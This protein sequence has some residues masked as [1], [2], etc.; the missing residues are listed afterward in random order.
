VISTEGHV[1]SEHYETSQGKSTETIKNQHLN[2]LKSLPAIPTH[3]GEQ[4]DGKKE[5]NPLPFGHQIL[6][7]F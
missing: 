7:H 1:I 5:K 3:G 6:D 4:E 2:I